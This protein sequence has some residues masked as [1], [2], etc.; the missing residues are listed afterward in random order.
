MRKNPFVFIYIFL[1]ATSFV[2]CSKWDDSRAYPA[3]EVEAADS[4]LA[5]QL[6]NADWEI[7]QVAPGIVWK[8]HHFTFERIDGAEQ[9]STI[10]DGTKQYLT[11]F[12]IN[13]NQPGIEIGISY[14]TSGFMKTSAVAEMNDAAVAVNGSFFDTSTGGATTYLKVDGEGINETVAGF[15][16][17]R[18]NGAFY[19]SKNGIV[20]IVQKP[21]AGWPSS[22]SHTVLASG[23]VLLARGQR[24]ALSTAEFNTLRHPR[25]IIGLTAENHFLMV[26]VDGRSSQAVGMT[27]AELAE[28]MLA[29]GC[30][31]ALNLDGGGSSTAWVKGEGVV[32]HPTDNGRF[33]H[34]GE[35]SVCNAFTVRY[36]Q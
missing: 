29:L 35:R 23:P 36:N 18:E 19:L 3:V 12:D 21:S 27:A 13:L 28:L 2:G 24:V 34:E 22:I 9:Q 4:A 8:R 33:D 7:T 32:N 5:S 16:A 31:V 1:L 20:R 30:V 17:F 6:K 10:F 11:I 14:V 15:N 26:V 25:T